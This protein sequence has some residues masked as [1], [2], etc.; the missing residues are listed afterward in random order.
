MDNYFLQMKICLEKIPDKGEDADPILQLYSNHQ[1]GVIGVFDGLGGAGGSVYEDEDGTTHTGAYYASRLVKVFI[2]KHIEHHWQ[3]RVT[4]EK[5]VTDLEALI[6][7]LR[8][9]LI[10]D[11]KRKADKLDKN[12]S[13]LKSS[14]IRRLPTTMAMIYF[15]QNTQQTSTCN[16]LSIW[17]GDSRAY[18]MNPSRGLQQLTKDDLKISGDALENLSDDSPLSN[19]VNADINFK[20]SFRF[21][22]IKL[23]CIFIVATDGCFGYLLTPMHFE[24][25]LLDTFQCA[26]NE[27]E[28]QENLITK[29]KQVAG[30][31]ASMSLVAI[32]WHDFEEVKQQFFERAK[33]LYKNYI[34]PLEEIDKRLKR[35]YQSI[36]V[37]KLAK[38]KHRVVLWEKYKITYELP[39]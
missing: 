21:D 16:C 28:W 1:A 4:Q 35:Y 33:H 30:D 36:E 38:E 3:Q 24:Y 9:K 29:I 10:E 15:W 14:L 7:E 31:D 25:L 37:H 2:E 5:G 18:I 39:E 22:T 27:R 6:T 13:R 34:Q 23:P 19:Y 11:L 20:L 32:G 26:K 12:P 17:A 8:D